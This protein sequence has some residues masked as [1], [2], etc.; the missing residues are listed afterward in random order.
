MGFECVVS[1]FFRKG[2][3]SHRFTNNRALILRVLVDYWRRLQVVTRAHDFDVIFLEKEVFP[4]LPRTFEVNIMAKNVPYVCDYDDAVFHAY[5]SHRNYGIGLILRDK[6][7]AVMKGA[8]AVIAGSGHIMDYAIRYNQ[9]V[10]WVPTV[11][12]LNRYPD[13]QPPRQRDGIFTIGWIG[14]HSTSVYLRIVESILNEFC[15][16]HNARVVAIGE[17]MEPLSIQ[18]FQR[19]PWS[20]IT[21]VNN[22]SQIDVGI[23]PLPDTP[24]TRAKCAFKLIQYMGC[25]K[26]TISSPVG[27]NVR[28]V[29]EGVN[30]F[31]AST[32][33]EWLTALDRLYCDRTLGMSMGVAGREKVEKQ[34]SL[35]VVA[36]QIAA[37]LRRAVPGG[38]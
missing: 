22:L 33:K 19:I 1:P 28:V 31:L 38:F 32:P 4:F 21:E 12:D 29:E 23:M 9:C 36:P 7:A 16:T 14:S 37:I 30:G 25:W 5:N 24:W 6:I 35:A 20:E 10:H 17:N 18:S 3:I 8:N 2:Y 34:Y 27:E 15:M 26:P 11:I 13:A